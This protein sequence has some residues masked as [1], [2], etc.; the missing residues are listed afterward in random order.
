MDPIAKNRLFA[1]RQQLAPLLGSELKL[2]GE[3]IHDGSDTHL[4]L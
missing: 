4:S 3:F 2:I 1:G